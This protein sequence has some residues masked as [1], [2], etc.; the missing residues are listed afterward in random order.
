MENLKQ[1]FIQS[2]QPFAEG[3]VDV[4]RQKITV[5]SAQTATLTITALGVYEA[6]LNGQKIGD[7]FLA[8]GFTYY[9]RNLHFQKYEVEL[10]AGENELIV[11][12][13]QG[14][15]CGRFT[16]N[17]KLQI[18]GENPAVSWILETSGDNFT[19]SDS[20]EELKSSW[21]YAGLYDGE[22]YHANP[23]QPTP[24]KPIPYTGKLPEV[25]E[26]SPC[27]LRLREEMPVQA[28]T[29]REDCTILDF[30]QNF[31]GVISIDPTKM[32][33]ATLKLRHGEI[34]SADGSLY[35]TNLRKAKA[36]ILYCKGDDLALYTPKFTYM[37]FR[38]VE[39][40]GVPY[41]PGLITAH[42]LYSD[43][44]RTGHFTCE[45]EKVDQLYRN[46]VWGQKSNY[47]E[48]PTDCP[49]RDERMGYTGDGH[50]FARTGS[51]NFDTRA[52][53]KKFLKDVRYSQIDNTEGYIPSTVPA[54]GKAG[55]GFLNML[56]WGNAITLIPEVLYQQYG[57][58]SFLTENYEAMKLFVDC[59]CRKC[60]LLGL[61]MGPS[62]GDW[63]ALGKDVAYMAM[64]NGPVSNAFIVHDLEFMVWL[65][66]KLG[67]SDD[68]ARYEKQLIKT[69]RAYLRAFVKKDGTM[70]D[71]YQGAYIMALQFVI[72]KGALWDKVFAKLL[73][74][75]RRDGMQTGFFATQHLLPMLCDNGESK[76][77]YDLLMQPNC[78]GWMYQIDRG[79]TTTWERWDA[80]REDGTVNETK[81]SDNNMVSF[82]HYAFGSVGEFYYRYILG[83]Q[84]AEP[85]YQ[86]IR[87]QPFFDERL[88][89]V[90]G[91]YKSVA[92][93]IKITWKMENGQI[94]LSVTTPAETSLILP[95]GEELLAPGT[96]ERTF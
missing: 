22:I 37:G 72:P 8:P 12:L 88:G 7:Q 38:Y 3:R 83:I 79:A 76:L 44:E 59:E 17:N 64:H 28:I 58:E 78:P 43:M 13:G 69:R 93:E 70:K 61:W 14:W 75:I 42:A 71:D 9:H 20:V 33:G 67:K 52:F 50:V 10:Q 18:Y 84:P 87:I 65:A 16:F 60:K 19:S 25:F 23:L 1:H 94:S 49:Q 47:V 48:V 30:G 85:G 89:A 46:Q 57:D 92:G 73:E 68:A 39:L 36:E 62:L 31:A 74:R 63:L 91:S 15:Y 35:T 45:N 2:N 26:E 24:R 66:K 53:W 96:Y 54:E 11:Y 95:T 21:A 56:G 29:V 4:F 6:R 81:M 80:L 34:L 40:S 77:A 5:T 86:R 90:E 27:I 41:A 51:Y 55:I 82:N 32:E